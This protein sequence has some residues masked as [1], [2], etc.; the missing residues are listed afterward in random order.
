MFSR[1]LYFVCNIIVILVFH[2]VF[3]VTFSALVHLL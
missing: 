3:W 1:P 2:V